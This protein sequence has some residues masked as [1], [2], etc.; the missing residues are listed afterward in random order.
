MRYLLILCLLLLV[1]QVH[2]KVQTELNYH[3]Y[4]AYAD[5]NSTV[6]EALNQATPITQNNHR[7][8]GYTKWYVRWRYRWHEQPNGRCHIT[9]VNTSITGDIQL[10]KLE[11]ANAEQQAIFDK[12][13]NALN[14]HEL[15]HYNLGKQAGEKIDQYISELP[16]MQSCKILEKTANDFGYQTL[17]EYRAI[18][19][20]YDAD[21]QHGKTQGAYLER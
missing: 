10:P 14:Q 6:R 20:Q 15:G 13:I 3:Y 4:T 17:D 12:Y 5:E 7:Y 21:T 2:A 11:N 18:E 19:K 16:E 8:H 1:N 9:S